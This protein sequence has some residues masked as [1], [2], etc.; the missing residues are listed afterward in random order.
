MLG[1]DWVQCAPT[2]VPMLSDVSDQITMLMT[3]DPKEQAEVFVP[4]TREQVLALRAKVSFVSPAQVVAAQL[5]VGLALMVAAF[6]ITT[7]L[8]VALSVGYGALVVIVPAA[9]FARGLKRP[10]A[11]IN[12]GFAVFSFFLWELVKIALTVALLLLAPKMVEDL[13]WPSLLIGLI[14]TIKVYLGAALLRSKKI[15]T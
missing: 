1:C 6:L 4:W 10:L 13:S 11:N 15:T 8:A 7:Q 9:V 14:V 5:V 12:A 3:N 2:Y